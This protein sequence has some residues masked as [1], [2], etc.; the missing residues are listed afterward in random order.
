MKSSIHWWACLGVCGISAFAGPMDILASSEPARHDF[1][2]IQDGVP[3]VTLVLP[4]KADAKLK[5]AVLD[6]VHLLEQATAARLAVRR[7]SDHGE[8]TG[9]RVFIGDTQAA[10]ALG[11]EVD[12]AL[13]P[14][15]EAEE[16]RNQGIP[17]NRLTRHQTLVRVVD[18]DLYIVGCADGAGYGLYELL[19][20]YAGAVWAWPGELGTYLPPRTTFKVPGDLDERFGPKIISR[21][22][23]LSGLSPVRNPE[24]YDPAIERF[25]FTQ[26]MLQAYAAALD[27]YYRRHRM[28][29]TETLPR[30]RHA[31]SGWW[32]EYGET[33]PEWFWMDSDGNR[34]GSRGNHV[35]MCVSNPELH[36]HIVTQWRAGHL[37]PPLAAGPHAIDL[38]EADASRACH[39]DSCRAWDA[40]DADAVPDFWGQ[41]NVSDRYARLWKTIYTMAREHD[42]AVEIT[43]H[44]YHQTFMAPTGP[45][46]LGP[47]FIGNFCP[48]GGEVS[49]FPMSPEAFE[50]LK[51]QWRGWAQ[52]GIKL[53]YRPNHMHDGYT[54]PHV[55]TRQSGEFFRYAFQHGMLA[56]QGG[57]LRG[58]W[59]NQGPH[60]YLTFR[61]NTKPDAPV[62]TLLDEYY[63]VFGPAEPAVR[64]YFAYWEQYSIENAARF[65]EEVGGAGRWQRFQH[66][67]H[68]AY[69]LSSFEPAAKILARARAAAEGHPRPEYLER[70]TF[71]EA[72]LEH[73]RLCVLLA[74]LFDGER[75]LPDPDLPVFGEAQQALKDL[76]RFRR[77][78]EHLLLDDFSTTAAFELRRWPLETLLDSDPLSGFTE[79]E[80][81]DWVFCKDPHNEG[82]EQAWYRRPPDNEWRPITVPARWENTWVS[83]RRGDYLGYG[84]Y[85]V[86]LDLPQPADRH[87]AELVLAFMG[88]D[89][90]AWVYVN[91]QPVGE[92]SIES[93]GRPIGDLWNRPFRVRIAGQHLVPGAA[94]DIV[95]RVHASS[96]AAGIWQPVQF[97]YR[98]IIAEGDDPEA[99]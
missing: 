23:G 80:L 82:V 90:Q 92:H 27:T 73:A 7:E 62:E 10:R 19:E 58:T 39:C 74:A 11:C 40:A 79:L 32:T 26:E 50:W 22:V 43:S 76:I 14:H 44:L 33:H 24:E 68:I 13:L 61:Q 38:G 36:R 31:F 29:N 67:V 46:E 97:Y 35:N 17:D 18:G 54:M 28:G 60:Y 64:E 21:Q 81:A 55:D 2:W 75:S 89:E 72:G 93:E 15:R 69:P 84:W 48:W 95:V 34:P 98:E 3:Q 77:Q 83:E 70:I 78:H 65:I 96:G 51:A 86:R 56:Y 53:R 88:V 49:W 20:R 25:G 1:V 91:G 16:R 41:R 87:E 85:R 99:W 37:R 9:V 45:V 12:A 4:D 6:A 47:W 57:A 59:A 63:S 42:P 8:T 30:G 66:Q 52:T 71:L 5:A 94:N